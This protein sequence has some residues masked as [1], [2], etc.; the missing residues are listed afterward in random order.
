MGGDKK[1]RVKEYSNEEIKVFWKPDACI[2]SKKCWKGLITVF[3][4]K[5]KPWINLEGAA[6][7]KIKE[8]VMACP[9]GALSYEAVG[10]DNLEKVHTDTRVEAIENGPLLIYGTLQITNSDGSK[11]TKNKTTAFCRCGA[12]QNKPYCDG[13]HVENNFKG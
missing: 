1:E 2:H 4:P 11:E 8:Q 9:S 12:S 10:V 6:T 13:A 7:E 5:N 3:N